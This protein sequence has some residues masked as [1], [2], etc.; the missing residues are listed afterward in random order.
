[1]TK[2]QYYVRGNDYSLSAV[3]HATGS[4]ESCAAVS[5]VICGLSNYLRAHPEQVEQKATE[6]VTM[7]DALIHASGDERLHAAFEMAAISIAGIAKAQEEFV[8]FEEI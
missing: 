6:R 7:G 8:N 4:V 2:V 1:M 5:A 3:G